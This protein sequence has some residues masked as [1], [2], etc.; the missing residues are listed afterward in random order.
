M[1]NN[2]DEQ[3]MNNIKNMVDSGNLQGAIS[4]ISPEMIENFSKMMNSNQMPNT[5]NSNNVQNTSNFNNRYI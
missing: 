3:T 1:A 4:Q 5:A 2:F